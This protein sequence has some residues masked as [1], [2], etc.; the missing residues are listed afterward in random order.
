MKREIGLDV[1]NK[2]LFTKESLK[3]IIQKYELEVTTIK[4]WDN[5][6]KSNPELNLPSAAILM[7]NFKGWKG[8]KL[9]LRK[10][11][12]KSN[13][14]PKNQMTTSKYQTGVD[15]LEILK[16]YQDHLISIRHWD[17]FRRQ[18][19]ELNLPHSKVISRL[20]GSWNDMKKKLNLELNVGGWQGAKEY[21]VLN[22]TEILEIKTKNLELIKIIEPHKEHL[23]TYKTWNE[24]RKEKSYLKLPQSQKI[25]RAFTSWVIMR[26]VLGLGFI[27][28]WSS[29]KYNQECSDINVFAVGERIKNI[30]LMFKFNQKD[31]GTFIGDYC[32]DSVYKWEN[33]KTFPPNEAIHKIQELSG[34]SKDFI[35]YG[36]SEKRE[37]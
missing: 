23:S 36:I 1:H 30:R 29:R 14:S 9:A 37:N 21:S 32:K 31:F 34:V 2:G 4:N 33:G 12:Y 3:E 28:K 25:T 27:P 15:C 17:K 13:E 8:V 26:Q 35:L 22:E 18:N 19:K 20:F 11:P 10:Y 24:Y 7:R 6:K 16:E 5:F